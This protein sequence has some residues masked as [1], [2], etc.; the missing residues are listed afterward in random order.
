[1]EDLDDLVAKISE[2]GPAARSDERFDSIDRLSS[3]TSIEEHKAT[4]R[5]AMAPQ[6]RHG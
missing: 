2:P 3:V 1:M 5:Q 4:R 6:M